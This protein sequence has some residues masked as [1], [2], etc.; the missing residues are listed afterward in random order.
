M[1]SGSARD[2]LVLAPRACNAAAGSSGRTRRCSWHAAQW[3]RIL[4]THAAVATFLLPLR[5]VAGPAGWSSERELLAHVSPAEGMSTH[6]AKE[7]LPLLRLCISRSWWTAA[8]ELVSRAHAHS[9]DAGF[10][11]APIREEV[12]SLLAELKHQADELAAYADSTYRDQ[13]HGLDEVNCA[14]QWAQNST[15][16]FLGVKYATRWSAPGAIEV[17]N[18]KVNMTS[19]CFGLS[20][21][22][23]HSSVRKHYT[24]NLGLFADVLPAQSSWSA[25]SVGRL[26]AMLQ[27]TQPARWPRLTHSRGKSKHQTST[28]LDMEERWARELQDFAGAMDANS[29]DTAQWQDKPKIKSTTTS[30]P[31]G[32][33][34]GSRVYTPWRKALQK[35]WKQLPGLL[36]APS[37]LLVVGL[38]ALV[39]LLLAVRKARGSSE[40][41]GACHVELE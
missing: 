23:H 33:K 26:T 1:V 9:A 13:T 22:G 29:K 18:V 30:S 8:R 15:T 12:T 21:F 31:K 14:L 38:V 6:A 19:C 17:V 27:K 4:V 3:S 41:S 32:R 7:N 39:A 25:A 28:W 36:S 10:E 35:R 11:L 40:P 24:V 37:I 2:G 5:C 20:G 16:V 34:K